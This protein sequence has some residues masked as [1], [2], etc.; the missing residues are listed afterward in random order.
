[1]ETPAAASAPSSAF[2]TASAVMSRLTIIPFRQPLDSA[3]PR[4][5]TSSLP[6]EFALHTSAQVFTVPR[7]S[8][9]ITLC[10]RAKLEL[11]L[12]VAPGRSGAIRGGRWRLRV[13]NDLIAITQIDRIQFTIRLLNFREQG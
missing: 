9:T 11:V 6:S 2:F 7:S 8:P 1:M 5:A 12:S 13:H 4:P 3:T 10:L